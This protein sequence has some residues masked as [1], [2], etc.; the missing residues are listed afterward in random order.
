[1]TS[2]RILKMNEIT[3]SSL[4]NFKF[5]N[6]GSEC[7]SALLKITQTHSRIRNVTKALWW[8]M[9]LFLFGP[10]MYWI[11][12][13]NAK[14]WG[15]A[16]GG[17][18]ITH[19][20]W[21]GS[22]DA[23]FRE[24]THLGVKPL[25]GNPCDMLCK[26]LSVLLSLSILK[27]LWLQARSLTRLLFPSHR[28]LPSDDSWPADWQLHMCQERGDL[29]PVALPTLQ[30]DWRHLLQGQSQV[31]H[32]LT[33]SWE[34]WQRGWGAMWS[35]CNHCFNK[36]RILWGIRPWAQNES[37]VSFLLKKV[38]SLKGQTG[39]AAKPTKYGTGGCWRGR[40]PCHL[41]FDLSPDLQVSDA[42]GPG[43]TQSTW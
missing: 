28:C 38:W 2:L 22:S 40:E 37:C 31:L 39:Q 10:I 11:F 12:K 19:Q 29:Q 27:S 13:D 26:R 18:T 41:H 23:V 17:D 25:Q 9:L 21:G 15:L 8:D 32:P 43:E 30:Q 16:K 42:G 4:L 36:R 24:H 35:I 3:E 20:H 6:W 33:L 5:E 34:R 14:K 7:L 1:M